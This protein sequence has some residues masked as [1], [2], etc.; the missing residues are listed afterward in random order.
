MVQSISEN[1]ETSPTETDSRDAAAGGGG[2]AGGGG[3]DDARVAELTKLLCTVHDMSSQVGGER[4][5]ERERDFLLS[6]GPLLGTWYVLCW[7]FCDESLV[8]RLLIA[9]S[10]SFVFSDT[11]NV[12]STRRPISFARR[13][14]RTRSASST[15]PSALT[16]WKAPTGIC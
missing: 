5:R 16:I 12:I 14:R 9:L 13:E 4:E 7:R 15:W 2:D 1:V 11:S 6:T 3:R 8:N 10:L